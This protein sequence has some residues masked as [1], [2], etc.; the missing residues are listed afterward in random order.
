MGL[1]NSIERHEADIVPVA[2]MFRAGI[3][4]SNEQFHAS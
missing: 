2:R 3:A 4:K 1:G